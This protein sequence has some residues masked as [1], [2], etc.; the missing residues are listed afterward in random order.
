MSE[1]VEV[2]G[3]YPSYRCGR[4]GQTWGLSV[5]GTHAILLVGSTFTSAKLSV[6]GTH[7]CCDVEFRLLRTGQPVPKHKKAT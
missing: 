5:T 4:C 2:I 7:T 1:R 3:R 6:D